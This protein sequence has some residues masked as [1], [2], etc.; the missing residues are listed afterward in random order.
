MPDFIVEVTSE[1]HIGSE[2]IDNVFYYLY[3][4]DLET[5][6][7]ALDIFDVL[8]AA[9]THLRGPLTDCLPADYSL[10]NWH[11]VGY[12]DDGTPSAANVVD[13]SDTAG[14][15]L[16]GS[17]DGTGH[18]VILRAQL[19][20]LV[21]L[22]EGA[23]SIRRGYWA[24]GPVL[25]AYVTDA[26]DITGSI[27]TPLGVLAAAVDDTLITA[28][29]LDATPLKVSRVLSHVVTPNITAYRPIIAASVRITG[30]NRKSRTNRR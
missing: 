17:R 22:A 24:V 12:K 29:G 14:G 23:A 16:E 3:H 27:L 9:K 26:G 6:L 10:S 13:I 7:S 8:T 21:T 1:G 20:H 25:S 15:S 28:E 2:V 11:G 18:V 30:S 19:G 4:K 5:D